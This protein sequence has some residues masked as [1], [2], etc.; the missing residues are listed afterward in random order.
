MYSVLEEATESEEENK[1]GGGRGG[2]G[3]ETEGARGREA[4]ITT[5]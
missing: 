3:G 5:I 2:G 4:N 1:V